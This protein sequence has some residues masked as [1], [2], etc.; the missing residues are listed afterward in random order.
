MT[1]DTT[2]TPTLA[3]GT[4]YVV[5]FADGPSAEQTDRRVARGGSWDPEISSFVAVD[6]VETELRYRA[7]SWREVGGEYQVTYKW[8]PGA[9]DPIED[10]D[11]RNEF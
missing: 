2:D 1:A 6:G 4:E 9:G 5:L 7:S 8:V 11:D 10:L 3:D